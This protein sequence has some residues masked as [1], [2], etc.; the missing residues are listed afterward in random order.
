MKLFFYQKF[1]NSIMLK[2]ISFSIVLFL[3][4][5]SF[6]F[7]Q[8]K[9]SGVVVDKKDQPVSYANIVFKGSNEGTVSDENGKFY[10]ESSK[11]YTTLVVAFVGFTTKDVDLEK[12]VTYNMKVVL[13]EEEMLQE[14]VIYKGKTSKKNNPALD[15]LRKIWAVSYTHLDVYKRQDNILNSVGIKFRIAIH[16]VDF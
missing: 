2:K 6:V 11:N 15:I 3:L 12:L 8:T 5:S 10:L 13:N 9:V 4:F 1:A 16:E 7:S 14:V